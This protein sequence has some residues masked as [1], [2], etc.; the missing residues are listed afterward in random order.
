MAAPA[1]AQVA[2]AAEISPADLSAYA[3]A[4]AAEAAGAADTAAAGYAIALADVPGDTKLAYLAYRQALAAGDYALATRAMN[5][6]VKVDAAPPDTALLGFAVALKARDRVGVDAALERMRAGPLQFM[7]PVLKAWLAFERHEE[8]FAGLDVKGGSAITRRYAMANRALLLIASRK[9]DEGLAALRPMLGEGGD[10]NQDLKIDA[11]LLLDMTGAQAEADALLN[12]TRGASKSLR[13]QASRGAQPGAAFGAAHLFLSLAAELS[14]QD[15]GPLSIVLTRTALLLDPGEDRARL[16]LAE[17]LSRGGS[18][19]LALDVLGQVRKDGPFGRGAAKGVVSALRRA[20]HIREAIAGARRLAEDRDSTSADAQVYGDLLA[21]NN[22]FGAAAA[23]YGVAL[24]RAGGDGGW[25][26]NFLQGTALDRAG[27]WPEALGAL[28][29]AVTLAPGQPTALTYLG[30][31]QVE[32]RENLAEAQALLERARRLRPDDAE[33][34]DSLARAYYLRGDVI[35][36]LPLLERAAQADPGGS[37]VNEHLGDAY[38]TLGRRYEARYAW[39]AAVI[40]ADASAAT[41]IQAKL[42]GG[43]TASN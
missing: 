13:R 5:V 38:W 36:A 39:R 12:E 7:E 42:A 30:F 21:G 29:R 10:D 14:E 26:L 22:Q 4:R 34:A 43:L 6:L 28:R 37:L 18:D 31:A 32:H 33:I 40:Y 23:A 35:R 27:R 16:Y 17:A 11:V 41:R 24:K 1:H 3:R 19:R 25:Y 2:P 9:T 20:G 15:A 8:V